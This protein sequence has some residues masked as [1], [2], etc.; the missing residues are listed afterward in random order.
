MKKNNRKG[1]KRY[2]RI[3]RNSSIIK[4]ISKRNIVV[5]A[6]VEIDQKGSR[7]NNYKNILVQYVKFEYKG[8]G[9]MID[10]CWLQESD[11]CNDFYDNIKEGDKVDVKF[12][13][14]AYTDASDRDMHG[15]II[16][17][18]TK[19]QPAYDWGFLF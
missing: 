17:K 6:T 15:M 19:N 13:F 11:Y 7:R 4:E 1:N 10:H 2:E 14:Y 3:E 12:R 18:Y 8:K 16:D 9:Y 5:K